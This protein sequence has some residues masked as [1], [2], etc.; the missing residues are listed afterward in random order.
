MNPNISYILDFA[1]A[2]FTEQDSRQMGAHDP[3]DI[4]FNLQQLE[5][6]IDS[7][8]DPYFEFQANI[9]MAQF[10]LEIE[11]VYARTLAMPYG[12]QMKI[13]QF[14][15]PFGRFNPTHPHAWNF[16]NQPL[17]LGKFMGPESARG[18]G[19]E[20][21]WLA[22][23]PWFVELSV[24]VTQSEGDCCARSFFNGTKEPIDGFEDFI[25]FSRLAQFFDLGREWGL[26][27]GA[28]HI[29]GENK[30]GLGNRSQLIGGDLFLRY[31]K[32][33]SPNRF[34]VQLQLEW[35]QRSRQVPGDVL[36][37]DGGLAELVI[38]WSPAWA[39]GFRWELVD[40]IGDDPLNPE[41]TSARQRLSTQVT[42]YPSH[43]SRLR[44]QLGRDDADWL[45]EDIWSVM[46]GLE[47]L[48]GAHGAHS[49]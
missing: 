1:A 23:L 49:Y 17:F 13:G 10:G 18:M 40:G 47:V 19:V 6:H 14:L 39:Q 37:D 21:S 48:V 42:W 38:Q 43:F 46:L 12:L 16:L 26:L 22:P 30:S 32:M 8:V 31:R 33:D 34:A 24:G 3:S 29:I 15:L 5:L 45:P 7:R 11:E 9:V 2:Y 35:A 44:L 20:T 25:L 41:W 36:H 27:L 4:G 28:S